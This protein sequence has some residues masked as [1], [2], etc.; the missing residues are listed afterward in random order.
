MDIDKYMLFDVESMFNQIV[1]Q[2]RKKVLK[3]FNLQKF[4]FAKKCAKAE[5]FSPKRYVPVE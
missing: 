5:K 4:A 2:H 3:Y 1:K